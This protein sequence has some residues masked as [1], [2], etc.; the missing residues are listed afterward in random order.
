[1]VFHLDRPHH[2]NSF[3]SHWQRENLMD[4]ETPHNPMR[5]S[6]VCS[7]HY[8]E[9]SVLQQLLSRQNHPKE[10]VGLVCS[11]NENIWRLEW[12]Q[13]YSVCGYQTFASASLIIWHLKHTHTRLWIG[14]SGWVVGNSPAFG[15]RGGFNV[16]WTLQHHG[17]VVEW[18]F[19]HDIWVYWRHTNYT[20]QESGWSVSIVLRIFLRYF[21]LQKRWWWLCL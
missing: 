9:G 3:P 1:M 2:E 18:L 6:F 13:L 5:S 20:S 7:P 17:G 12:I 14:D 19:E 10:I 15:T 8:E 4:S 11:K 21:V 16:K